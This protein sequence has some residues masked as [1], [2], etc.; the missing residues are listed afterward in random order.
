MNPEA[1]RYPGYR[2]VILLI[3]W[4]TIT[5]LHWSWY[6]IPSLATSIS[7]ELGLTHMQYTLIFTAPTL[8]GVFSSIIG[9][10]S[11]DR[12]GIRL[13]VAIALFLGGIAGLTRAFTL[14]FG[15]MFALMCLI[16]FSL[17]GTLP[18]LPKLVG[19]W[20][21]PRQVGSATGFYMTGVGIG[22]SLGL[23]TGPLLG[24]WRMAFIYIGILTLVVAILW[25]LLARNAPK[26]IEIRRPP[27]VSGIKR[28]I[29]SKNI[30]L[31]GTAA[32]LSMGGGI[33]FA[34]NLPEA[35]ES[36]RGFSAATA[37][38]I[39]SIFTFGQLVG[40]LLIPIISDRIELRKPLLYICAPLASVC[41]FLCWYLA[42]GAGIWVLTFFG[43]FFSGAGLPLLF[44]IPLE[45]PEIGHEYAGGASGL[46]MSSAALGGFIIPFFIMS[47]LLATKTAE[48]YSAGFLAAILLLAVI[49][50][51]IL[52]LRET[53]S[54]AKA[55]EPGN[56]HGS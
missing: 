50:L 28:G 17:F 5:C 48:A 54:R 32:F 38:A 21:P 7:P 30:R 51:P 43:G 46:V 6:L 22:L 47:S 4:V 23:L 11:A 9:G 40:G 34:G 42:Q 13:V 36:F 55:L 53:G 33:A 25:T 27:M 20:F 37:G 49:L 41:I 26:G 31:L 8:I 29:R 14:N 15:V 12:Y 52:F 2:W 45:L 24:G 18:N 19:I 56:L 35:L 3:A 39:T 44:T 16:G 10:A 1:V